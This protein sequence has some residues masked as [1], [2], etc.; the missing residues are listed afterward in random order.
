MTADLDGPRMALQAVRH[1][2]AAAAR[3][4]RKA[5]EHLAAAQWYREHFFLPDDKP[6]WKPSRYLK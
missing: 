5:K 6:T 2:L 4:P 3:N 1:H